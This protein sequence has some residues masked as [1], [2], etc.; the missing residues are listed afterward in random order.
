MEQ[1]G[2]SFNMAY[3]A[4]ASSGNLV[5]IQSQE[6]S[7]GATVSFT[8][9]ITGFSEYKLVIENVITNGMTYLEMV[10]SNNGGSSYLATNYVYACGVLF[11]STGGYSSLTSTISNPTI[12]LLTPLMSGTSASLGAYGHIHFN[13][14]SNT[15][16][17]K[18]MFGH[19]W[20]GSAYNMFGGHNSTSTAAINGI[21]FLGDA[22]TFTSGT[23]KLYGVANK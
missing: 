21:R 11:E 15:S 18:T 1:N 9:G 23:F 4:G 7:G 16:T 5:L 6:A 19:I 13:D 20:D 12:F 10:Y 22:G 17:Y 3:N 2:A 14:L 8:T